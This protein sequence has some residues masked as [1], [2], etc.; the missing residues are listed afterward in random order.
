MIISSGVLERFELDDNVP[1]S[2]L[3]R[4]GRRKLYTDQVASE[5]EYHES[6]DFMGDDSLCDDDSRNLS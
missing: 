5:N 2:V 4:R 6:D 3:S 1:T